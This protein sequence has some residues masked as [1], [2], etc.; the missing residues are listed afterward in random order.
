MIT[1]E[2]SIDFLL[3]HADIDNDNILPSC[4]CVT[5]QCVYTICYKVVLGYGCRLCNTLCVALKISL[6]DI[7]EADGTFHTNGKVP[8]VRA[9]RSLRLYWKP[10]CKTSGSSHERR[11]VVKFCTLVR[12]LKGD[13]ECLVYPLYLC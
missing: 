10:S 5:L 6:F 2:G 9:W 8:E 12:N 11:I 3:V 4:A 7:K 13:V 1:C